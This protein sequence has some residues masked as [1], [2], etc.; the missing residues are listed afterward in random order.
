MVFWTLFTRNQ[1]D[2]CPNKYISKR[3]EMSFFVYY[4]LKRL[5]FNKG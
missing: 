2:N 4:E 1:R 3:V 5:D